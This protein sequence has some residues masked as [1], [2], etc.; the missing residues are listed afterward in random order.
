MGLVPRGS[1]RASVGAGGARG[2]PPAVL[3]SD[4]EDMRRPGIREVPGLR[5]PLV[6]R[7]ACPAFSL[8]RACGTGP[9]QRGDE[10]TEALSPCHGR[11]GKPSEHG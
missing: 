6:I 8:G 7:G 3:L 4:A 9:S 2:R 11:F 5:V 1:G 10:A